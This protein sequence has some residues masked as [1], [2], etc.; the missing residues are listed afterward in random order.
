MNQLRYGDLEKGKCQAEGVFPGT[1]EPQAEGHPR[2]W[3]KLEFQYLYPCPD[4]ET[5]KA[6]AKWYLKEHYLTSDALFFDNPYL[7]SQRKFYV[8]FQRRDK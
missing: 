4:R 5:A 7:A 8:L 6:T 3:S 1:F 2:G